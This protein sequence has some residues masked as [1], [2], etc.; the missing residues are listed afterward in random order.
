MGQLEGYS[1]TQQVKMYVHMR[2]VEE[3][4]H[5][6]DAEV[7]PANATTEEEIRATFARVIA[8]MQ[9]LQHFNSAQQIKIYV[10]MGL[11]EEFAKTAHAHGY[12]RNYHK[13]SSSISCCE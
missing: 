1:I 11:V 5:N 8:Q 2:L 6:P 3:L 10:H 12:A 4:A 7:K 13:S 9:D